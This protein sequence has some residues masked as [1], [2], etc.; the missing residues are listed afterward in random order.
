MY[1]LLLCFS[2][3][4]SGDALVALSWS[5]V[6]LETAFQQQE[7]QEHVLLKLVSLV[8]YSLTVVLHN[9]VLIMF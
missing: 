5:C 4:S 7:P 2:K 6:A 9:F 3:T 1:L 8:F